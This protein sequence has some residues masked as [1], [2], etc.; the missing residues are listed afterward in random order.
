MPKDPRAKSASGEQQKND[1]AAD[2]RELLR[3]AHVNPK[4]FAIE[5]WDHRPTARSART[6]GLSAP[7]KITSASSDRRWTVSGA[8]GIC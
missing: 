7:V 6:T 5:W 4:L 1:L 3:I 8:T 2:M